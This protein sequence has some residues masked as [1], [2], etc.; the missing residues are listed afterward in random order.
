MNMAYKLMVS[1]QRQYRFCL[2]GEEAKT[3]IKSAE[4]LQVIDQH[5]LST[6]WVA[7]T[8]L[9]CE[10]AGWLSR[11]VFFAVCLLFCFFFFFKVSL[12]TN[13]QSSSQYK[14]SSFTLQVFNGSQSG[15][16][17]ISTPRQLHYGAKGTASKFM[18][19]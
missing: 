8:D 17:H 9:S 18:S 2:L 15:G 11:L 14:L 3:C 19:R 5:I 1:C 6:G 12:P 10:M 16:L 4:W 7:E 13:L